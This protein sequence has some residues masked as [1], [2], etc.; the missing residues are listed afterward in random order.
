METENKQSYMLG[1]FVAI[2]HLLE[3]T[4]QDERSQVNSLYTK[5]NLDVFFSDLEKNMPLYLD[6]LGSLQDVAMGKGKEDLVA[7]LF[8]LFHN[9]PNRTCKDLTIVRA[10]FLDGY[11]AQLE[12][13][14][15]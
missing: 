4:C 13:F 10:S 15:I 9:M 6:E 2:G 5:E 14:K 12:K 1:Q 8:D 11:Y 7:E 3:E